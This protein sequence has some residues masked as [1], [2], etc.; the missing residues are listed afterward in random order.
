MRNG[1]WTQILHSDPRQKIVTVIYTKKQYNI[2]HLLKVDIHVWNLKNVSYKL[3]VSLLYNLKILSLYVLKNL[4]LQWDAK[5]PMP[6]SCFRSVCKQM[7]KF[8][9]VIVDVLPQHQVKVCCFILMVPWSFCYYSL[10]F[11]NC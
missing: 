7:T 8:H 2:N 3:F 4:F 1:D 10:K 6:S 9:E 5:A 11:K